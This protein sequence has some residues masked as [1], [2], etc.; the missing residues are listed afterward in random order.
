MHPLMP[1]HLAVGSVGAIALAL[2]LHFEMPKTALGLTLL[3]AYSWGALIVEAV[4]RIP[5]RLRLWHFR[6]WEGQ[7][8]EFD[9]RQIRIEDGSDGEPWAV[10]DDVLAAMQLARAGL[11]LNGLGPLE[12]RSPDRSPEL[13]SLAG[14]RKLCAVA[15]SKEAPR[16]LRWFERSVHLPAMKRSGRESCYSPPDVSRRDD[17][18]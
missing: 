6:K 1:L 4:S 3:C 17:A 5:L 7:Y 15:R 8:Y 2:L 12:Y 13:L 11:R 9:G 16:F 10:A 14:I 18:G